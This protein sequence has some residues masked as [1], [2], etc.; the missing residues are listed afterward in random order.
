M[1]VKPKEQSTT[2]Y[3][4][5]DFVK[6]NQVRKIKPIEEMVEVE[7]EYEGKTSMKVTGKVECQIDG[8]PVYIWQMNDTSRNSLIKVFGEDTKN[9]MKPIQI[10]VMPISGHDSILVD[11]LGTAEFNGIKMSGKQ[12]KL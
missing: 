2:K 5:P 7:S 3:L 1:I 10:I 8:K 11:E 4:K 6:E 9:W 12:G